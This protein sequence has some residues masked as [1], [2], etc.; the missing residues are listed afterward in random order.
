MPAARCSQCGS[1]GDG[2]ARFEAPFAGTRHHS[3]LTTNEPPDD[4]DVAFI[5]SLISTADE[6]LAFLHEEIP[7]LRDRLK[8]LEEERA[9]LLSFRAQN[10]SILSPLRRTP[11]EILTEIFFLAGPVARDSPR[12]YRFCATDS[13]WNLSYVCRRWRFISISKASLWSLVALSYFKRDLDPASSFPLPMVETQITRAK[14]LEVCFYGSEI[15][16]HRPQV[17]AFNLLA[18]HS[19]RWVEL[20]IGLTSRLAPL[21]ASLRDRVPLVRR[22]DLHWDNVDSQRGIESIDCFATAPSL[23]NANISCEYRPIPFSYRCRTSLIINSMLLGKCIGP[24]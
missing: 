24:Y 21:L 14:A 17:E 13:P 2:P 16:D 12:R 11:P 3:L 4:S 10:S 22:L 7:R 5:H 15:L 1:D 9:A 6:R 20:S 19:S 23:V 8:H 18:K